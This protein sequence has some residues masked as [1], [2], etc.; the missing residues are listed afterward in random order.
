MKRII[1]LIFTTLILFAIQG[2]NRHSAEIDYLCVT[3]YQIE[4]KT[5]EVITVKMTR[6]GTTV[7]PTG[8]K[9]DIYLDAEMCGKNSMIPE[10]EGEKIYFLYSYA[11]DV[12]A[13][14]RQISE[15][16]LDKKNWTFSATEYYHATYLLV[17]T[18]ALIESVGYVE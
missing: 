15:K 1:S 2:C 9:K 14:D 12:Y 7:I 17:I 18:D 6:R 4:N 16:I 10:F 3:N 11:T 8:E 5:D 13:D